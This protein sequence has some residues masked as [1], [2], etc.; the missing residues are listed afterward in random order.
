MDNEERKNIERLNAKWENR[1][2]PKKNID[3]ASHPWH[4]NDANIKRKIESSWREGYGIE[5]TVID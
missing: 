5:K 4:F 1:K 2:K 3:K